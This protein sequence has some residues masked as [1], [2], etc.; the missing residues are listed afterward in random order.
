MPA[1]LS[2]MDIRFLRAHGPQSPVMQRAL[3]AAEAHLDEPTRLASA[4]QEGYREGV[5]DAKQAAG[6][7][8]WRHEG[9][10]VYSRGMDAG[11]R[12]QVA[13]CVKAIAA[14]SPAPAEPAWTPTHRHYKGGLYRELMRG[15]REGSGEPMVAYQAEN[16]DIWFRPVEEFD[17]TVPAFSLDGVTSATGEYTRRYEPI[18]Q[19]AE[20]SAPVAPED[21]TRCER[22]KA[23]AE[24][25]GIALQD[26]RSTVGAPED[27]NN[28]RQFLAL[29]DDG[30]TPLTL[31]AKAALEAGIKVLQEKTAQW[32]PD[33]ARLYD[34]NN[35]LEAENA[36]LQARN[37]E[38]VEGL[39]PLAKIGGEID[40]YA[41]QLH[42]EDGTSVAIGDLRRAR[43][44]LAAQTGER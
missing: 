2:L 24:V 35:A 34:R 25:Y 6:F 18:V 26:V 33:N 17:G 31:R 9:N 11:A 15:R 44:Y 32:G 30:W 10:D 19:S 1:D 42:D 12:H 8:A 28:W 4:R 3:D 14:L 21:D 23:L 22:A 41:P 38:L 5:A 29:A 16:G 7:A 20:P 43:A 39:R 13:E 37:A 27:A 36:A 40:R